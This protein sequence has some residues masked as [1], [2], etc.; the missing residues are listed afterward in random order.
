M[1]APVT[2]INGQIFHIYQDTGMRET[3][4]KIDAQM[5]IA[6][7]EEILKNPWKRKGF[8]KKVR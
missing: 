2:I 8:R 3:L 1:S 6:K 7:Q 4:K 5:K